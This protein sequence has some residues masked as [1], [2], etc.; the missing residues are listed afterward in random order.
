MRVLP[1]GDQALLVEVDGPPLAARAAVAPMPGVV[2]VVA[3]AR[4][5]LVRFDP[6]HVDRATLTA[7]IETGLARPMPVAA[8]EPG[9]IVAIAVHYDGPD[10]AAVADLV[11]TS[12]ADVISWHGAAEYTVAFCGFAPGFAY[13]TGLDPRLHLPRLETPRPRVPAGSVAIAGEYTATYPRSSPGGW[14][15]I[16]RTDAPLWD[17]ARPEPALLTPG[18]RVRFEAAL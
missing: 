18:T 9:P 6:S 2:E 14:H 1:Y 16:G 3:A 5:L 11:G 13:L 4:T 8:S 17:L 12:V 7:D 15:L 10:L